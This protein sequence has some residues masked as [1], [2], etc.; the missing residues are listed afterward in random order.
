MS[1]IDNGLLWKALASPVN[2]LAEDAAGIET[3]VNNFPQSGLLRALLAANGHEQ[4]VKHAAAYFDPAALYKLVN[5]PDSLSVVLPAQIIW[6]DNTNTLPDTEEIIAPVSETEDETFVDHFSDNTEPE[7]NNEDMQAYNDIDLPVNDNN[8]LSEEIPTYTHQPELP[9]IEETTEDNEEEVLNNPEEVNMHPD[10]GYTLDKAEFFHQDIDDDVYDEIVSIEDINL[11]QLTAH[12][13]HEPVESEP[14][15]IIPEEKVNQIP[16]NDHF[17]IDKT[18]T[19]KQPDTNISAV[20]TQPRSLH[21]ENQELSRYND[22]KMPYS[23]MWW[24]DKT[25]K[26]YASTYQPYVFNAGP[27]QAQ[28]QTKNVVDELQQQYVENIFNLN[29]IEELERSTAKKEIKFSADKKE[30]RI[31]KRFIQTEPQI[32]HPTGI[33]LDNE[34]KA[35]KS[36]EDADE[37]VTETLARIYT[38]QM[39]YPKA[40][41]AYKKLMLKFPEKSLYFASQIEQI[42]KKSN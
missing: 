8:L 15:S 17:V 42:E 23:F 20:I 13:Q 36:S 35:K 41:S 19:H 28:V 9:N 18:F 6:A 4:N 1:N 16:A 21:I 14:E 24:L 39:L 31:I 27:A 3:L 22:D 12:A 25:R 5:M 11:G 26:E 30:D 7:E 33:R 29:A 10:P 40:I 2:T 38:E 37:I 32:K 34:N